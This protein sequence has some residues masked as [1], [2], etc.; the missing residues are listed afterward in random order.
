MA[1]RDGTIVVAPGDAHVV[2]VRLPRGRAAIRLSREP[3]ANGNMPSVDPM[4]SSFAECFGPRLLA[5]VL[6]G[7][8]R[9]GLQ[10][11][12]ALVAAGGSVLVQDE[13][14]SAVWGMPAAAAAT[15]GFVPS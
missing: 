7:M 10:G 2:A 6:S 4:F 9:D 5:V 8:G 12:A 3:V 13:A 14:S 15:F 11:A 1:L